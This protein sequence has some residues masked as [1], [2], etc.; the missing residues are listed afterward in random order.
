MSSRYRALRRNA[1][2]M[3]SRIEVE[4]A[5]LIDAVPCPPRRV[6]WLMASQRAGGMG[7]W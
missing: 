7:E 1:L 3:T 4:H 6:R 5:R 2:V